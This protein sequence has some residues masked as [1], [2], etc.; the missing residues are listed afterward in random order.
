ML[1][2]GNY[3]KRHL[4]CCWLGN[5]VHTARGIR[6]WNPQSFP[7][8]AGTC[9]RI[10]IGKYVQLH[11]NTFKI[12]LRL[13]FPWVLARKYAR[14]CL[15]S[16]SYAP[17]TAFRSG[18]WPINVSAIDASKGWLCGATQS[19]CPEENNKASWQYLGLALYVP[20]TDMA[21]KPPTWACPCFS[22]TYPFLSVLTA[23]V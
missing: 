2:V 1:I 6:S 17:G 8:G 5:G 15:P 11:L 23:N 7:K 21:P 20:A 4:G 10:Q 9:V 18:D 19:I 14:K 12:A 3:L 13:P 16:A 22:W